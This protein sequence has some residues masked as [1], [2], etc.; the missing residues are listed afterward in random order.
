M[1]D[2]PKKTT[3]RKIR[4]FADDVKRAGGE[5]AQTPTQPSAPKLQATTPTQTTVSKP[6]AAATG[7]GEAAFDLREETEAAVADATII[8]DHRAK[9]WSLTEELSRGMSS[10]TEGLSK[11]LGSLEGLKHAFE[12]QKAAPSMVPDIAPIVRAKPETPPVIKAEAP[13]APPPSPPPAAEPV[14]WRRISEPRAEV[15]LQHATEEEAHAFHEML[16]ANLPKPEHGPKPE[17]AF[18]AAR[19]VRSAIDPEVS[20][21]RLEAIKASIQEPPLAPAPVVEQPKEEPK[22]RDIPFIPPSYSR[23]QEATPIRTYRNDA[24]SDVQENHLSASEIASA[25]LNRRA[26]QRAPIMI[27]RPPSRAVPILAALGILLIFGGG[28]T[29]LYQRYGGISSAPV[30]TSGKSYFKT[31]VTETIPLPADRTSL[32]GTLA[33][34]RSS[35]T[36][37]AGQFAQ[38]I[39]D[40]PIA[41][42]VAVL[43]P[44]AP[45][46]FVRSLQGDMMFGAYGDTKTPFIV[47]ETSSFE[48]GFAGMLAWEDSMSADLAPFF[49]DPVRKS[50]ES[51]ALTVDQ[52]RPAYF[53]DHVVQNRDVRLL[54]D[55]TGAERIIY[56]FVD[57]TTIVISGNAET[58]D[59]VARKLR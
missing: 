44:R 4:T 6:L 2:A 40:A 24:I 11:G 19:P 15:P 51:G 48:S 53:K 9:R 20:R 56:T 28:G 41:S 39:I 33:S 46:T 42:V 36:L 10:W 17:H 32:L 27:P 57:E 30:T 55:E 21:K 14:S 49:G 34:A 31:D 45:G 59:A 7:G 58:L 37:G 12:P 25:E 54:V 18:K 23:P 26:V 1:A 29:F 43:D 38:W 8:R 52:T 13:S 35:V 5:S 47:V 3:I 16:V 22:H 50:Y